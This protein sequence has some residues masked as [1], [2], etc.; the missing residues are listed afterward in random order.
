VIFVSYLFVHVGPAISFCKLCSQRLHYQG[1]VFGGTYIG[2]VTATGAV[3]YAYLY[4]EPVLFQNTRYTLNCSC[5][6]RSIFGLFICQE[7]RPDGCMRTYIRT[8][9]TLDTL[10]RLPFRNIYCYSPLFISRNTCRESPV[11]PVFECAYRDI[12]TFKTDYRI[13]DITVKLRNITFVFNSPD[14]NICP[15]CRD[16]HFLNLA[17]SVYRSIV[18]I[19]NIFTFSA[20]GLVNGFLHFLFSLLIWNNVGKLEECSLHYCVGPVAQPDF[21]G[22]SSSINNIEVDL[23]FSHVLL[24]GIRKPFFSFFSAP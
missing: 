18:H 17:A 2:A 24:H 20:I 8:L 6:F 5:S 23:V 3:I 12:V 16:F 7:E 11:F 21:L 10:I 15:F 4:P 22:N 9:I 19:H 13:N 14:F 1:F